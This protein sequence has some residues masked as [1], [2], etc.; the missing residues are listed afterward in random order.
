MPVASAIGEGD[1]AKKGIQ[2][3][4]FETL[5]AKSHFI[6][7]HVPRNE[8]TKYMKIYIQDK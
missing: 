5:L 1:L 2:L 6:T 8:K 7:L 3:V 4:D